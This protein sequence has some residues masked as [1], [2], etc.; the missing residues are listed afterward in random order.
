[1]LLLPLPLLTRRWRS[2]LG[3]QP[4]TPLTPLTPLTACAPSRAA[5]STHRSLEPRRRPSVRHRKIFLV[6]PD[7]C[8]TS[9]RYVTLAAR[10]GHRH[11]GGQ[12]QSGRTCGASMRYCNATGERSAIGCSHARTLSTCR[13]RVHLP[14]ACSVRSRRACTTRV[15]AGRVRAGSEE[16]ND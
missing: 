7:K 10:A 4:P 13:A 12:S 16:A 2:R 14:T 11:G 5:R 1:P 6:P 9:E 3:L 8:P 15:R